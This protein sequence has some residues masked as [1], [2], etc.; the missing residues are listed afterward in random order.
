MKAA[1][2][3]V[4]KTIDEF[5]AAASSIPKA[6]FD[7]LASLEWIRANENYCA[8]GPSSLRTWALSVWSTFA[9]GTHGRRS[10]PAAGPALRSG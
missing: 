3:L 2:F 6:T 4:V 8:V 7:Y 1:A 10:R 5:D 9:N